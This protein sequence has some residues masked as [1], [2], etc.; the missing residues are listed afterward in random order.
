MILLYLRYFAY[1][2]LFFIQIQ[3]KLGLHKVEFLTHS[4]LKIFDDWYYV[5]GTVYR[6]MPPFSI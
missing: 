4:H 3:E 2:L 1:Y 5:F 6:W